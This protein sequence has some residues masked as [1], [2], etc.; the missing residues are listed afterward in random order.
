MID[1]EHLE[2]GESPKRRNGLF[3]LG[4][5][6]IEGVIDGVSHEFAR[7]RVAVDPVER[8]Q[9]RFA[10]FETIVFEEERHVES[11]YLEKYIVGFTAIEDIVGELQFDFAVD[12]VRAGESPDGKNVGV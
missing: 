10:P 2:A 9:S 1:Q 11:V 3:V 5:A 12:A 4:G 8:K 7:G 6:S